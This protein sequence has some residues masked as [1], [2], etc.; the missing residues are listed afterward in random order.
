MS[1]E[2]KLLNINNNYYKGNKNDDIFTL[3]EVTFNK[4]YTPI[5]PHIVNKDIPR[6]IF[7]NLSIKALRGEVYP[8]VLNIVD[9]FQLTICGGFIYKLLI[10]DL[11]Y[12]GAFDIDLYIVESNKSRKY[13]SNKIDAILTAFVSTKKCTHIKLNRSVIEL[14]LKV[15]KYN[16]I[17]TVKVQIILNIYDSISQILHGFDLGSCSVAFDGK[18]VY[19]T[20][21]GKFAYE[22]GFNILDLERNSTS[23]EYRLKKYFKRGFGIIMP[24][25]NLQID[26]NNGLITRIYN[27]FFEP[28]IT[29]DILLPEFKIFN[30]VIKGNRV[31]AQAKNIETLKNRTS[32]YE[33]PRF[34]FNDIATMSAYNSHAIVGNELGSLSYVIL[35]EWGSHFIKT[36]KRELL[37]IKVNLKPLDSLQLNLLKEVMGHVQKDPNELLN[38]R[39]NKIKVDQ[40]NELTRNGYTFNY[41][42]PTTMTYGQFNI[43]NESADVWYDK[44]YKN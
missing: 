12:K 17:E 13:L 43:I 38:T 37:D 5:L 41:I 35:P 40:K 26:T 23:Y 31:L 18:D 14:Y 24:N 36:F 4:K 33:D 20:S 27:Y 34:N 1:C 16:I 28:E 19:F 25:L 6:P 22:N 39:L 7:K 44:Y 9:E 8:E 11:V 42:K 15:Y 32:D 30:A 2:Y 29:M 21:V 10:E 3:N